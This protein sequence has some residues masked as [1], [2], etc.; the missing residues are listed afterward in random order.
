MSEQLGELPQVGKEFVFRNLKVSV[1]KST[2]KKVI[3]LKRTILTEKEVAEL[4][5][6]NEE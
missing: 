1:T 3:E 6:L 2:R 5:E 4:E